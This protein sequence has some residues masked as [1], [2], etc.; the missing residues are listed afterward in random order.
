MTHLLRIDARENRDR[1]L[2]AARELFAESGL[3]VT[4]RQIARRADVGPATL[5]RRFPTKR[6]LVLKAFE[7]E[8]AECGSIVH[9]GAADPDPWRGFC[10]VIER[11]LLLNARNQGFTDAFMSAHPDV[12]DFEAHRQ[13]LGRVVSTVIDRAQAAGRLR[14]DFG[15]DD[16]AVLLLAG[17]GLTAAPAATRDAAVR[18]FTAFMIDGLRVAATDPDTRAGGAAGDGGSGPRPHPRS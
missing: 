17:R 5:Y 6:D 2:A 16:F 7:N 1:V 11:I 14:P 18:R 4:M 12:V 15:F 9:D 10:D 8:L 13:E 3:E